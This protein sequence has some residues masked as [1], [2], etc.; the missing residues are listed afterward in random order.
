M[1]RIRITVHSAIARMG[2]N[3]EKRILKISGDF[4]MFFSVV[5]CILGV[6]VGRLFFFVLVP[7]ISLVGLFGEVSI[8]SVVINKSCS[9]VPS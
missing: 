5:I 7:L 8:V 4:L 3:I 6:Y 2:I 1:K 9:V